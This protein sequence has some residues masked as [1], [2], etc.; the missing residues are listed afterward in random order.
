MNCDS[1]SSGYWKWLL[2][3]MSLYV[4]GASYRQEA[5]NRSSCRPFSVLLR[6]L[7]PDRVVIDARLVSEAPT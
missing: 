4:E 2:S 6:G 3:S 7:K 5:R 1:V